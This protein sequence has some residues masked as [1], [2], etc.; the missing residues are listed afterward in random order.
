[1][2]NEFIPTRITIDPVQRRSQSRLKADGEFMRVWE[3]G[4][5]QH[6]N[7]LVITSIDKEY[8]PFYESALIHWIWVLSA[9]EMGD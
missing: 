1:M 9:H 3:L 8:I 5:Q 6:R 7:G 4:Y 2:S